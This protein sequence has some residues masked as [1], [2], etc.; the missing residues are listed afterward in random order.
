[1]QDRRE[2]KFNKLRAKYTT[3]KAALDAYETQLRGTCGD[4]RGT[5]WSTPAEKRQRDQLRKRMVNAQDAFFEH[6]QSI[7]PRNWRHGVPAYWIYESLTFADAIRPVNEPLSV[8]P[9]MAYGATEP[10]R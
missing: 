1:M 2:I 4:A 10:R 3:A 9:P 6:L 7:S 5:L 8:V